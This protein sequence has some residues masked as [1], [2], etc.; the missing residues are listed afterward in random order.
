MK[1]CYRQIL[2]PAFLAVSLIAA[3]PGFGAT[4]S[5]K[6]V[7]VVNTAAERIPVS[8]TGTVGLEAGTQVG[9][10]GEVSLAPGTRVDV[11][12][13]PDNPMH[14]VATP[15]AREPYQRT[16][17]LDW[18][19]GAPNAFAGI[20]V[21]EGKRFVIEFIGANVESAE[22]QTIDF[23]IAVSANGGGGVFVFPGPMS[24][25]AAG[26]A[27]FTRTY[28]F[29]EAVRLYH[30]AGGSTLRVGAMRPFSDR[31]PARGSFSV[32]GYLVDLP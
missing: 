15:E 12:N 2:G 18:V 11:S 31:E 8:A 23:M 1:L 3:A 4:V 6:D 29:S 17:N 21:P 25:V 5:E 13:T 32:S 7:R 20:E 30:D 16:A 24:R 19:E 28:R 9:V 22:D 27:I 14:V 10:S 26:S